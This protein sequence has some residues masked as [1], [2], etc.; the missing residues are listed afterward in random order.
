MKFIKRFFRFLFKTLF[1][2]FVFSIVIVIVFKWAPVP[3]TPL[4]VIKN[5]EQTDAN[6]SGWEHD[7]VPIEE[8]SSNLQL[9]VIC[10]EDQNFL[11]H[12]GFD[13]KAIEKA[14]ENNKKGKRL[15]GASSI[16]QQT[17]KNVFLWPQRSWLR[18]G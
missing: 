17:A 13:V 8:I 4:M 14:Y 6:K 12:H 16:S 15:K 1:W 2:L 11:K 10:S 9:A 18:K 7:W 3:I 5:M